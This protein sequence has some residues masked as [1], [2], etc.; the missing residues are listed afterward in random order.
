M[1]VSEPSRPVKLVTAF[2]GSGRK[3]RGLTYRA[4]RQFL[5]NLEARGDVRTEIVF[6]SEYE[7]GLCRGCKVCFSRGEE[8]C[9][10]K[11]GRDLLIEKM[12]ASDGIVLASPNYSFQ[13]SSTMKAFLDRLGYVFHRPI[14]F[15]KTFT[16]ITVQGF[17]AEK[18]S[19]STSGSSGHVCTA[20]S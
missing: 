10:L 18:R 5:K 17:L 16:S 15:G 7:L 12:L 13:V 1:T 8:H 6:L 3:K 20:T 9:P 14:F 19:R 11:G 4:T 2:I